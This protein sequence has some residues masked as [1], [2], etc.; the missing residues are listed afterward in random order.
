MS[1]DRL[2]TALADRYRLDRELGQG[3]MATVYLA[4]DLKHDRK[5]AIKVLKPELAAVI[6]AER[7]VV[8][9]KTTA[10]LQHPHILPLFDSGESDGFLWYA[11]P[12]IDGETLRAKLDRETQFG[13]DEAVKITT[14]VADALH[15]AHTQGVVHRDIKP[16]NILLHD[17]RP[18]VADFGIALA[19]SAAAG[20]RMTETGMSLGTPHYMSPEQ[21]TAEK[22]ISGRSDIYSLASVLFEM[23]AG[24]PPH[25]GG[26]A[27][28]IIMKI[29]A[30]QPAPV[31][32]YRKSVPP[33]VAAALGKALEKLPADRFA[34]AA[35]FSA[36]L[37]N[38]GFTTATSMHAGGVAPRPRRALLV[39]GWSM[40][41]VASALAAWGWLRPAVEAPV[42][43]YAM[44]FPD[45]QKLDNIRGGRIAISP[46]GARL[47][48]AGAGPGG[49][50]LL[51]RNRDQLQATPIPGTEFA[52]N[53]TFS[54]DGERVAFVPNLG[55]DGIRIVG[56]NGA[57]PVTIISSRVGSDG[58]TWNS[59][60]NLY[61]DG[62]TQG[63]TVGLMR[64]RPEGGAPT[65]VTTIDTTAGEG[66]HYWPEA[67]PDGRGV[68]FTIEARTPR[69]PRRVAVLDLT[70]GK[71]TILL[72]AATARYA[73]SGHLLYVTDSG[74]LLAV[75][76]DLKSLR[77][78]GESF[79]L[80]NRVATRAFGAVDLALSE[81]GTLLY[82]IGGQAND[83]SDLSYVSRDGK[84]EPL[85]GGWMADFQSVAISP[86]G[87]R[88]AVGIAGTTGQDVWVRA[89]PAGPLTKLSFEGTFNGRP[90][91][92]P[93]GRTVGFITN[94]N[95]GR[96]FW[97]GPADGSTPAL[98]VVQR[99]GQTV[100][101]AHW[102]RDGQWLLTVV[103][104]DSGVVHAQRASGGTTTLA[105][106][107]SPTPVTSISLSPDNRYLAYNSNETGAWE[108]YVRPFP[109][110]ETGRW[111]LSTAG[112]WEPQW[113]HSGRELFY[114]TGDGMLE[115]V[116]VLPGPSFTTGRRQ[117]LYNGTV[118]AGGVG[119][120]D[121]TPDDQRF[122]VIR[123]GA[124]GGQAGNLIV[125]ENFVQ[126]LRARRTP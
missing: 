101:E 45:D 19:L 32:Q 27:Q 22:E 51:L 113:S 31:T 106:R 93:D 48:Y 89:L 2:N 33:H 110:V 87:S 109:A 104:N 95:N 60:G 43:R 125:V 115:A 119:S 74:D 37:M 26:S 84:V 118:Y 15:Y 55:N 1:I 53:P 25:I 17:G 88:L 54:P 52:T 122:L 36:A 112:G 39:A 108:A 71:Y 10:A 50:R 72:Q 82:T 83:A 66:D 65:Q 30:E 75:P 62:L 7:F 124:T 107:L 16:E 116:E 46:D 79:A 20:G 68:L 78:T 35:E 77:I 44:A 97:A 40:A 67:L 103:N 86:D 126:E 14:S 105:L 100:Q 102:S 9:I 11:M 12:F 4:A 41:I 24:Q 28:Q 96:E 85:D 63:G 61:Y 21:A 42:L 29:I 8:E 59:D 69:E 6:G 5:V 123:P 13:I 90:I 121:V 18:V 3:G 76:F 114:Y 57:P 49:Q 81:S 23:L 38:P 117:Q 92:S 111:T 91:W 70:T 56:L 99:G 94:R 47:V 98:P 73:S 120:W 34:T 64:I 58:L 80:T